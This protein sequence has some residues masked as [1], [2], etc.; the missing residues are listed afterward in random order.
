MDKKRQCRTVTVRPLPESGFISMEK[1]LSK[2]T[3]IELYS[4][5][6]VKK[7]AEIL[8]DRNTM[9]ILRNL[10]HFILLILD[11]IDIYILY[12]RSLVE[13]FG[14]ALSLWERTLHNWTTNSRWKKI[15]SFLFNCKEMYQEW[16]KQPHVPFKWWKC[17][18]CF[19]SLYFIINSYF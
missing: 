4:S 9:T 19:I 3:W 11:M 6:D 18:F 1:W 13:Q 10:F 8:Q 5:P 14:P 15:P 16:K 7:K 17:L 12:I 2:E